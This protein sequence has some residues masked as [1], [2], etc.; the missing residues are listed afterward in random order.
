MLSDLR[1]R[2][3]RRLRMLLEVPL[4]LVVQPR[5]IVVEAMEA[6]P[7][8]FGV[9]LKVEEGG[10]DLGG[11]QMRR[12]QYRQAAHALAVVTL[13]PPGAWCR[14]PIEMS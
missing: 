10:Q 14:A 2:C 11:V 12:W 4:A 9:P 7:A 1:G 3:Q 6:A 5:Q 8:G 13:L